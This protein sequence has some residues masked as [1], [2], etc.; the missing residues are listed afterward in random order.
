MG[1]GVL[2]ANR[3]GGTVKR[4]HCGWAAHAGVVAASLAARGMTAAPTSIE[5]RFG[6]FQAWLHRDGLLD[7]VTDGLGETWSVPGIF[8][9]PYPANHFTHTAVDAARRLADQGLKPEDVASAHLAVATPTVRTIGE[10]LEVKQAPETGYQAQFSGPYAVA[11][12]LLGGGGLGAALD[13]YTDE[14]A[15]DESRRALMARVTVGNDPRCDEVYPRQFPAVLTVRTHSGDTLE[16][17]VMVNRGGPDDPLTEQ[18]LMRKFTD[19]AGPTLDPE[20]VE[21][22][23]EAVRTLGP[24]TD[25]R[26]L[27]GLTA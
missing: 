11:L 17:A 10:P 16:Q 13:D 26:E 4:M 18:E 21:R 19:N 7:V 12:G 15:Q 3:T 8:F 20:A 24:G 27:M 9:K 5:G 22:L 2:E 14:L 23:A 6:F 1:S 25:V